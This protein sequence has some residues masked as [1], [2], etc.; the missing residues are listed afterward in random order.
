LDSNEY[1]E[2]NIKDR[3]EL[4]EKL[5]EKEKEKRKSN[6]PKGSFAEK[7]MNIEERAKRENKKKNKKEEKGETRTEVEVSSNSGEEEKES[8]KDSESEEES[9]EEEEEE[10]DL[11]NIKGSIKEFLAKDRTRRLIFKRFQTFLKESFEKKNIYHEKI[12]KMASE[13]KQS[14]EVSYAHLSKKEE[15]LCILLADEP[16]EVLKIF[17]DVAYEEVLS[18]FSHYDNIHTEIYVRITDLPVC[19]KI[20]DLRQTHLNQLIKIKGVV[21]RRTSVFPQLK[22]I[23]FD[24][25]KCGALIGPIIINTDGDKIPKPQSCTNC[26]SKNGFSINQHHTL[27]RNYQ[28]VTLQ[29]SPGTGIFFLIKKLKR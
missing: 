3:V 16:N 24:C 28:K 18:H 5:N 8:K 14:L 21:T 29:E 6:I 11:H 1:D 22:I 2:I 19:E 15:D 12:Q 25:L 23:K 10:I 7:L 26:L 27:Y 20:R 17:N 4:E 13:N 9:E